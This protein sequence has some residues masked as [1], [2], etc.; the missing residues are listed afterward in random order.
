MF[1]IFKKYKYILT[2]HKVDSIITIIITSYHL[3][4]VYFLTDTELNVFQ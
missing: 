2:T 3:L 1:S 4:C